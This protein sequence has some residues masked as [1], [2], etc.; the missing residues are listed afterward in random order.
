MCCT[1]F[2]LWGV[3]MLIV[4]AMKLDYRTISLEEIAESELAGDRTAMYI[5]AA[6]YALFVVGCFARFMYVVLKARWA[7]R[8]E[9][10]AFDDV[11]QDVVPEAM[12]AVSSGNV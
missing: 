5:A 2:S 7:A 8:K 11:G 3:G 12:S 10:K 9:R 4:L 6:V 1:L